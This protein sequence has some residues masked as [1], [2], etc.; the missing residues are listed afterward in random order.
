[1]PIDE[2]MAW[3]SQCAGKGGDMSKSMKWKNMHTTS[4]PV[5]YIKGQQYHFD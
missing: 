2:L 4:L 1:M 5:V 3:E